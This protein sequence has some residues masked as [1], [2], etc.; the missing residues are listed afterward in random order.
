MIGR[1]TGSEDRAQRRALGRYLGIVID[2]GDRN[3]CG[4]VLPGPWPL[5]H[6]GLAEQSMRVLD[7]ADMVAMGVRYNDAIE[8]FGVAKLAHPDRQILGPLGDADTGIEQ[9]RTGAGAD[10]VG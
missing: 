1:M 8:F 9:N 10:Q 5:E 6:I 3:A 4:I 2:R 7:P